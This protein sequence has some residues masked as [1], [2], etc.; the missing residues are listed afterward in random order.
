VIV[1]TEIETVTETVEVEK[2][3]SWVYPTTGLLGVVAV[4]AILYT[5][6]RRKE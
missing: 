4:G 5:L 2:V 6:M 3:P 1:E